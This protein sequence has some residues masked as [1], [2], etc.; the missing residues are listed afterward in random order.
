MDTNECNT[1]IAGARNTVGLSTEE[2]LRKLDAAG[3]AFMKATRERFRR[4]G[5]W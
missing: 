1:V 2:A 5:E 3:A 4:D